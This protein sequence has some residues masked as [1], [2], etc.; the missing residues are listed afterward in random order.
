MSIQRKENNGE[1][2]LQFW[3]CRLEG[4]RMGEE[5]G[6]VPFAAYTTHATQ[7]PLTEAVLLNCNKTVA[8]HLWTMLWVAGRLCVEGG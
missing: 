5:K 3:V 8:A 4:E 2:P 6:H 1:A 7:K